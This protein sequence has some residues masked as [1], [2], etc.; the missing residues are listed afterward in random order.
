MPLVEGKWA[1]TTEEDL[2]AFD[3][4][5]DGLR[6]AGEL[7]P[8]LEQRLESAISQAQGSSGPSLAVLV[9]GN[10]KLYPLLSEL[11]TKPPGTVDIIVPVYNAWH[12]ARKCIEAVITRTTWPHSL[13]VVDDASDA[14]TQSAL[15]SQ[16][17]EGLPMTLIRNQRNRGFAS[18]VNR[19]IRAGSGEYVCLL[20]SDVLVTDGWLMKMILALHGDERNAIVCPATNNTAVVDV[21]MSPGASYLQMAR[22]FEKFATR[23]YPEILP[24][25]FCFLFRRS[26]LAQIG[27]FD[28]TF[29]DFGEET[30]WWWKCIRAGYRA[31]M[32]DDAY[33]FHE[34]A[35]SYSALGSEK[36]SAY[37]KLASGRFNTLWPEWTE[38]RDKYD[39]KAQLGPLRQPVPPT[40]LRNPK[41]LYRV[42]WIVRDARA[43]GAMRYIADLCNALNEQGANAKVVVLPREGEAVPQEWLGELR[44][45]PVYFASEAELFEDFPHRVFPHGLVIAGTVELAPAVRALVDAGGGRIRG[46][47]HAQSFDPALAKDPH[48]VEHLKALYKLLPDVISSSRWVSSQIAANGPTPFATIHPGVDRTLFYPRDRSAGDERPTVCIPMNPAV[49]WRG[50]DRGLELIQALDDD[51]GDIDLRI[52]VYG[53][54]SLPITSRAICLGVLTQTRLAHVLGTEVDVFC[55]PSYVHSYGMPALEA[56]ACDIPVVSFGTGECPGQA[57]VETVKDAAL[58][59]FLSLGAKV[60]SDLLLAGHDREKSV[61]AWIEAVEQHFKLRRKLLR[62][63]VVAPHLRKWGGPTTMLMIAHELSR[64][65]H[66]VEVV[67][68][69]EEVAADIAAMAEVPI[70]KGAKVLPKADLYIT[71]S[72]NPWC[73]RIANLEGPRVIMLKLSHNPRFKREEEKGLQQAWDAVVCSTQ[74][75]ADVTENPPEGWTQMAQKAHVIGWWHYEHARFRC[76]PSERTYGDGSAERPFVIGTLI[77]AHPTKGT[78]DAL[79]ELSKLPEQYH[80]R[81]VGIG[82]V[83]PRAVKK[84]VEGLEYVYEPSRD[85]L[86]EVMKGLDFWLGRSHGEGLG[87]MALEAMSAG[88]AVITEDE[89]AK[90]VHSETGASGQSLLRLMADPELAHRSRMAGFVAAEFAANPEPCIN[91]LEEVIGAI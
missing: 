42:A 75:L 60:Y 5:L 83:P 69:Y 13:I 48:D 46:C 79:E 90:P 25:G 18:T 86:A 4:S 43:C 61:S 39:V 81:F 65:G 59:V 53:V 19:G 58:R 6:E 47:L 87:R 30:D 37:R 55:D 91:A 24:T 2:R 88:V 44:S 1:E 23:R 73:E 76:P 40:L 15:I 8:E 27:Y 31:V 28:E 74:W 64:R 63:C 84:I 26:L 68:V 82:E 67:T 12:I 78:Q 57:F 21:P 7:S 80:Y 52:L 62:T 66:T 36:H 49:W 20:N 34:R 70:R 56:S 72:D 3:A 77:H 16:A 45:A 35:S 38:W 22:A 71:N 85:K 33:V 89:S 29:R 14:T 10:R 11:L 41:D 9:E 17:R 54:D 32:A 50:W 51:A